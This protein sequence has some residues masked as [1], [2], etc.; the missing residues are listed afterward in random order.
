MLVFILCHCLKFIPNMYE[1]HQGINHDDSP[2]G[3]PDWI[4]YISSISHLL[5]TLN[6]SSD[7]FIYFLKH[8]SAP[9]YLS[10]ETGLDI[11]EDNV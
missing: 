8:R 3:W 7:V 11:I 5:I 9:P 6:A 10:V 2:Q 4:E 1:I